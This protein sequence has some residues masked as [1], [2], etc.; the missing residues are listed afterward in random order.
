[1]TRMIAALVGILLAATAAIAPLSAQATP[2]PSPKPYHVA[3]HIVGSDGGWD[4]SI[5]DATSGRL[6]IARNDA[7]SVAAIASGA[8][9]ARLASG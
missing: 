8:F 3:G 2:P 1:M 7:V 9:T 6:H 5:L 4:F